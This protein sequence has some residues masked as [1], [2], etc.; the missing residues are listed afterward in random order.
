MKMRF[1]WAIFILA[2]TFCTGLAAPDRHLA[3]PHLPEAPARGSVLPRLLHAD[4][5]DRL[6]PRLAGGG[7]DAGGLTTPVPLIGP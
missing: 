4:L 1:E 3:R 7:G 2:M 5:P 6:P